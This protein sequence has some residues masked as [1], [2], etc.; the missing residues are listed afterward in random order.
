M[1]ALASAYREMSCAYWASAAKEAS[2]VLKRCFEDRAMQLHDMALQAELR[3]YDNETS[4]AP[5][6]QV[7]R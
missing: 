1:S 2:P 6:E 7:T 5:E 4:A 3:L